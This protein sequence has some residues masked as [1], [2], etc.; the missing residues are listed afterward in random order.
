MEQQN[1]TISKIERLCTDI[2]RL[3][4]YAPSIAAKAKPGQF[5][6]LKTGPGFDPLL[7]RPFSIHN[8]DGEGHL[9]VIFKILGK[10]TSALADLRQSQTINIVGP[11]GNHFQASPSMCL[12]GGGLGIAPLLFLARSILGQQDVPTLKIILAARN[13]QELSCFT[14]EFEALDLPLYLATDD[15]SLGHHGL[16]TELM[17]TALSGDTDWQVCSCGPHPMM[18]AVAT[19]CRQHKWRCQVSL[20]TMMAC[21]ISACLGCAVPASDHNNTGKQYLHVCQ[22][23]PIFWE[24]D[25]KWT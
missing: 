9:Q 13:K 10:G 12:I 4:L 8:I 24:G 25:I 19:I 20:E 3:T 1:A 2:V 22:D 15:G 11:L 14:P 18:S 5:I 16:V 7:R 23:G 21:G 6:N 17:P